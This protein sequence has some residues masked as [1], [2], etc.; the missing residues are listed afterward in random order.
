MSVFFVEKD[1]RNPRKNGEYTRR[2]EKKVES[3][4]EMNSIMNYC[5]VTLKFK[6]FDANRKRFF[7]IFFFYIFHAHTEYSFQISF[8]F[9]RVLFQNKGC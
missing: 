3:F 2:A 6:R 1:A 5:C 4:T 7:D 9:F 8:T